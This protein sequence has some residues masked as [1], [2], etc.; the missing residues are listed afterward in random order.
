MIVA[1]ALTIFDVNVT[2]GTSSPKVL[3]VFSQ[4]IKNG[5]GERFVSRKILKTIGTEHSEAS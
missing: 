1:C 2:M 4:K 5:I 3:Y